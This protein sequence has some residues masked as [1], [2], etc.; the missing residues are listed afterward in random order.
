MKIKYLGTA[1]YEG[2][3]GLFCECEACQKANAEGGKNIRL[4][5]SMTINE[6]TLIDFGPDIYMQKLRYNL[7]LANIRHFIMTHSHSDHF[8]PFDLMARSEGNYSHFQGENKGSKIN[9]YGN[10]KV[11]EF[12]D[13][14]VKVEFGGH[15]D[16]MNYIEV[17]PFKTYEVGKL[18]VTPLLAQHQPD[19]KSLIYLIEEERRTL[20]YANDTGI[21]P[22]A[23]YEYL[24]NVKLD[25]VS[26]DC[27]HGARYAG[28]SGHLGLE[29]CVQTKERLLNM[30]STCEETTF[31]ITHFSHNG[32]LCHEDLEKVAIPHGFVVA[33]DG[34]EMKI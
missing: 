4:R 11:K 29:T 8:N 31:I 13:F 18:K 9:V 24:Q 2:F 25:V 26:L 21:F 30:G 22:E 17:V 14:A 16:F 32:G 6:D 34:M 33:Y 19:E 3:P 15:Q 23:T 10:E 27:T 7:N 20:L 12:F 28:G 1:A 5:A